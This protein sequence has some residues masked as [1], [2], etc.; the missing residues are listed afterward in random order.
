MKLVLFAALVLALGLTS[1]RK[2]EDE[3]RAP[4]PDP[5]AS[6]GNPLTAPV[7]YLGAVGRAKKTAAKN[8]GLISIQQAIQLFQAEENRFP[9]N[10]K[11]VV[12]SGY[13]PRLPAP[14]AGSRYS[15]DPRTGHVSLQ[16]GVAPASQP[17]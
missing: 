13:L 17:R 11:E 9:T 3:P 14:P 10:L 6:S 16:Q 15:Y 4:N 8:T 7:D 5:S 12:D 1:C 2:A